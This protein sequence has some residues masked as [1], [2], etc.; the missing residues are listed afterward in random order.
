MSTPTPQTTG[1]PRT[2]A[3]ERLLARLWR[4][5]SLQIWLFGLGTLSLCSAG[6]ILFAFFA[7]YGLR[8]PHSV[9]LFHALVLVAL[10]AFAFWRW[11][12]RPLSRRP[13]LA[14][15]AVL[16]ERERPASRDLLVSAVQLQQAAQAEGHPALVAEVLAA[17]DHAAAQGSLAGVLDERPARLRAALGGGALAAL[18]ALALANPQLART[19]A[20]RLFD[21]SVRW[22][23]RTHLSLEI[24]LGAERAGS[25][26][27][28]GVLSVRIARGTDLPVLVRVSGD[29][30]E[31]LELAVSGSTPIEISPSSDGT[32]RTVLRALQRDVELR[33]SGGDD[34]GSQARARVVVL[35]PP[36]VAGVALSI[37]PPAYSG[38]A[39]SVEFDKDV[40]VLA[41][42]RVRVAVRTEPADAR[43]RVRILPADSLRELEPCPFPARSPEEP[44]GQGRGLEFTAVESLRLRFELEDESGL[45][46]PDPGL[47]AVR[48]AADEKPQVTITTPGR[49]EVDTLLGGWIPLRARAADEFGIASMH[50]ESRAAGEEAGSAPRELPWRLLDPE[51]RETDETRAA[52]AVGSVRVEVA[53]L[54]DAARPA[55]VG[56]Q[57]TLEVRAQD[58]RPEGGEAS[59]SRSAPLSVRVVSAE[60]FLRRVQ[61]RLARLRLQVG[62]LETLSR[63]KGRRARE[64]LASLESDAPES[65][66]AAGDLAAVYA[67]ARRVEGDAR[68]I[69]RELCSIAESVLYARL[70][71]DADAALEVLDAALG[72]AP[73]S[74]SFPVEAWRAFGETSRNTSGR[75]S[76]AG[77]LAGLVDLALI[78][79]QDDARSAA[80]AAERAAQAT[81]VGVVHAALTEHLQLEKQL[82]LH[83]QELLARLAEWDNFQSIL[84]LTKD[85]LN[86]QKALRERAKAAL[87]GR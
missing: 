10:P 9:R 74:G 77:Q 22:P 42:S 64:L 24:P 55:G 26:L 44:P 30:P 80:K 86:R 84:S 41:G 46:N 13:D 72:R 70:D 78:L 57:Y 87:Q 23:Q 45:T 2:P 52:I 60:E 5:L 11:I 83:V 51:E 35:T 36:D 18:G 34:D 76:L 12:V 40:E 15:C 66:V 31:E 75:A 59:I 27:E 71:T 1:L 47:F 73:R 68:S 6:W 61:D 8:V 81:D 56:S 29:V 19:F 82:E 62:E 25:T 69:A 7:D 16:Y 20:A 48:V 4:R 28:D 49:A 54:G 32:F 14:G 3:L 53:L 38:R 37:E 17:A 33:A 85:I 63:D 50:W 43:A 21:S 65:G 39:P 79:D 67:G 58:N